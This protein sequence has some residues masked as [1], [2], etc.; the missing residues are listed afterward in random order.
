MQIVWLDDSIENC[1]NTSMSEPL[2]FR[3]RPDKVEDFEGQKHLFG[4][5]GILT[6]ALSGKV[7][8]LVLWGPPGSGKTT[9]AHLIGKATGRPTIQIN[10]VSTGIPDLKKRLEGIDHPILFVDEIHRWS[11]SQQDFLLP[12]VESGEVTLIGSTTENPYFEVIGPLLSRVRVLRLDALRSS[13]IKSIIMKA[14]KDPRGLGS[15]KIDVP[16][17]VM[18]FLI[19][20]A[21]GDARAA[22]NMLEDLVTVGKEDGEKLV[23]EIPNEEV[24]RRL[25]YD[26]TGDE[27]YHVISAFIKSI[28]GSDVDAAIYWLAR[29]LKSGE[30]PEFIARRMVILA[31]EDIGLADPWA[32]LIAQAGFSAVHEV[33]MPE[34]SLIMAEVAVYLAQSPKSNSTAKALWSAQEAVALATPP[35]PIHLRNASFKGAKELGYGK[36]YN[37]PHNF[38]GFVKQQ[39]LPD[40]LKGVKFFEPT[41]IGY[42]KRIKERMEGRGQIDENHD[43]E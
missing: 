22:L 38:G 23:L 40:E 35:V 34:A 6:N 24:L 2:A 42:E 9:L 26:K 13:E 27:H 16:E 7:T 20:Y 19:G 14:I 21:S 15:Q 18:D 41:D 4:K 11:K 25:P 39:Y 33:G 31:S 1:Y 32:I 36:D 30:K 10:A 37:Y 43:K 28:R 29:M 8:S 12:K 17:K 5:D 3:V